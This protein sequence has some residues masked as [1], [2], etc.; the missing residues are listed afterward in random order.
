[1]TSALMPT[2]ARQPVGFSRGEGV[3]LY[4]TEGRRYLDTTAGIAV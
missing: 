3:W 2:Y 1:M 4:D